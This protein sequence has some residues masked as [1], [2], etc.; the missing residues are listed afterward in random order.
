[1]KLDKV[2]GVKVKVGK[3]NERRREGGAFVG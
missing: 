3:K 2:F 1:L